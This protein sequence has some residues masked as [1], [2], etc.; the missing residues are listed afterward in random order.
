M[1]QP[2]VLHF[3]VELGTK[4]TKA[5][6]RVEAKKRCMLISLAIA[7]RCLGEVG[8][9][10]AKCELFGR[11][12]SAHFTSIASSPAVARLATSCRVP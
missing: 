10:L 4:I 9:K 3:D 2:L 5:W 6:Y 11:G 12:F 1:M 8:E 7:G